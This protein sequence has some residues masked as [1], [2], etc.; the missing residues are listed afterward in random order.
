MAEI[1]KTGLAANLV[2]FFDANMPKMATCRTSCVSDPAVLCVHRFNFPVRIIDRGNL[3]GLNDL[4]VTELFLRLISEKEKMQTTRPLFVLA[5]KDKDFID[6]VQSA[7]RPDDDVAGARLV[8]KPDSIQSDCG[9]SKF[10]GSIICKNFDQELEI[11]VLKIGQKPQGSFRDDN[12]KNMISCLNE[13]W[14]SKL[15]P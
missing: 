8:F 5:T 14:K 9:D 6:D 2:L 15:I 10:L 3:S 12:I 4:E 11:M 7:Y 1:S 13:F